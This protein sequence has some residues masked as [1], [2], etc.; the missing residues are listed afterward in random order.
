[1]FITF[2]YAFRSFAGRAKSEAGSSAVK[3]NAARKGAVR[4]AK[5]MFFFRYVILSSC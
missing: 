5:K 4:T 1:M 3:T 2:G